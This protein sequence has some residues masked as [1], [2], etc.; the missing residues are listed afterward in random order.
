MQ[1]EFDLTDSE[2]VN[3]K[4]DTLDPVTQAEKVMEYLDR[5]YTQKKLG[6]KL[7]KTR[8]WV[9]KRV[10]FIRALDKL[11]GAERKGAEEL[12]R[13]GT[14]S[15]DVVV[16]VANL[17]QDQRRQIISRHPTV[18]EARRLLYEYRQSGSSRAK[19]KVLEGKLSRA[20][21]ELEGMFEQA[22][23]N[24]ELSR[25]THVRNISS[26]LK[27]RVE[28]FIDV[29]WY[30]N[31]RFG[32]GALISQDRMMDEETLNERISWLELKENKRIEILKKAINNCHKLIIAMVEELEGK[33]RQ[34]P[35]LTN[36]ISS[37]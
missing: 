6:E 23:F 34:V 35:A 25:A 20:Y 24:L 19:L 33:A 31:Q 13:D 32:F 9:A 8:D 28:N 7:S 14:I 11:K 1:I 21:L 36:K 26:S 16:L 12:V 15:M 2:L 4:I 5:N 30:K 27:K 37:L 22:F 18:A 29:M 3:L 10:R 17:P